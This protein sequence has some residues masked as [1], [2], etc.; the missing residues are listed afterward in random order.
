MS[1]RLL[2]EDARFRC[3]FYT[4]MADYYSYYQTP[5]SFFLAKLNSLVSGWHPDPP[6]EGLQWPVLR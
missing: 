4:M 1:K 2:W 5:P 3:G 6:L